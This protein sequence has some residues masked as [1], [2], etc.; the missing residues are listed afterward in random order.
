MYLFI[1]PSPLPS[2][3][4]LLWVVVRTV[5]EKLQVTRSLSP[6]AGGHGYLGQSGWVSFRVITGLGKVTLA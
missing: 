4:I 3:V 6:I 1:S 2:R 5:I